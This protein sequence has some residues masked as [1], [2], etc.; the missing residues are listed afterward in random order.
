VPVESTGREPDRTS[1]D[2]I[3]VLNTNDVDADIEATV[4]YTEREPVGPYRFRVRAN[5]IRRV[6]INDL[7]D[8]AAVELGVDYGLVIESSAPVVVQ[9]TRQDTSGRGAIMGTMAFPLD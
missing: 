9:T 2:A 5:R 1:H 6:R 3:A 7:I 8:P 4:H